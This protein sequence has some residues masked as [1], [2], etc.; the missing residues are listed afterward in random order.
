MKNRSHA[1]PKTFVDRY[2]EERLE[3]GGE[4]WTRAEIVHDLRRVGTPER[5]IDR[6]LQGAEH[7]KSSG[8]LLSERPLRSST[9]H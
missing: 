4:L 2:F 1:A 5:C 8:R 6:W 9:I 7:R 3:Y